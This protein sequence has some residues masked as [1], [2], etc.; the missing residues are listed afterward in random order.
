MN[1]YEQRIK[2][3]ITILRNNNISIDDSARLRNGGVFIK[4]ILDND[5]YSEVACTDKTEWKFLCCKNC[6]KF[7]EN[8]RNGSYITDVGKF[9]N[10]VVSYHNTKSGDNTELLSLTALG[11]L[12]SVNY[13]AKTHEERMILI[14]AA[15]IA[16]P[17]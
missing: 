8:Y 9:I 13:S 16:Y 11:W 12:K 10:D 5:D 15:R 2:N 3:F 1:E 14:N 17:Y 4:I 6:M 7:G